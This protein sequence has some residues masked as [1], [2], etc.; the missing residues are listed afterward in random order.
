MRKLSVF[1]FLM[2]ICHIADAQEKMYIYLN[3]GN[4]K[5][6]SL[7]A[8]DSITFIKPIV[9]QLSF[10]KSSINVSSA[11]GTYQIAINSNVTYQLGSVPSIGPILTPTNGLNNF[12]LKKGDINLSSSIEN[13]ILKIT[14]Q[15]AS[16]R[17][18]NSTSICIS[19]MSG[20]VSASLSISQNGDET[21]EYELTDGGTNSQ[22]VSSIL[23]NISKSLNGF[24]LFDALYTN[25]YAYNSTFSNYNFKA[26]YDHVQNSDNNEIKN[27]WSN[28]YMA[29][30]SL[31]TIADDNSV[32]ALI[33]NNLKTIEALLY[34]ELLVWWGNV[35]Y[36]EDYN[37]NFYPI[38]QYT[39]SEI[40]SRFYNVI[41]PNLSNLPDKDFAE[42]GSYKNVLIISKNVA[43]SI[44]A[45]MYLYEGNYQKAMPLFKAIIDSNQYELS[46]SLAASLNS[47]SKEIVYGFSQYQTSDYYKLIASNDYLPLISYSEI[48]LSAA[49]CAY[50]LGDIDTAIQYYNS[51]AQSRSEVL[52][53]NGTDFISKL[54]GLWK[55]EVKN[56]GQYFAFLKRN[57][58]AEEKLSIVSYKKLMPFPI[59]E[60]QMN[61]NMV[62]NP[63]Y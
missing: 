33:S 37:N 43:R 48:I 26:I 41:E 8:I 54:N 20:R 57:G 29:C 15:P 50:K 38:H 5:E 21:K 36:I 30:R 25:I 52:L 12:G 46:T 58:L 49:E 1:L 40:F 31:R 53:S 27:L 17:L 62:Q 63:G 11:G 23:T 28:T 6:Y 47:G 59:N 7:S 13:N 51:F 56:I 2:V 10:E 55:N 34:Y 32:D 61:S 42:L 19:D 35:P 39:A 9:P 45:R 60:L 44:L 14:V 24:Y 22:I 3:D 18:M 16:G 4:I